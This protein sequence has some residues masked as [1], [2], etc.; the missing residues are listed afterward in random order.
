MWLAI[1][2]RT[3]LP[4]PSTGY[5]Y[6]HFVFPEIRVVRDHK[7]PESQFSLGKLT[8]AERFVV[9]CVV[10]DSSEDEAADPVNRVFSYRSASCMVDFEAFVASNFEGDVTEFAPHKAPN[11][12]TFDERVRRYRVV[13]AGN[14]L[15]MKIRTASAIR[16]RMRRPTP[17]TG[18]TLNWSRF[19]VR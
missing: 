17:S 8:S 7:W 12:A 15:L 9:H 16:A 5:D 1:R 18:Y 10:G 6:Q 19:T 2:A 13:Y 11:C 14:K 3:R 4:T